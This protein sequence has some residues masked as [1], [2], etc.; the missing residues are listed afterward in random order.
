M[1][2][3]SGI[4]TVSSFSMQERAK[5]LYDA[6]T[7]ISNRF[8]VILSWVQGGT[9]SFVLGG[10]YTALSLAQWRGGHQIE[11]DP[12]KFQ[13][14]IGDLVAFNS[15]A[16]ALVIGLGNIMSALPEVAKATGA[17]EKIFEIF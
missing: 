12:S 1:E 3:V 7:W 8:G 5:E 10:F 9:F 17:A 15:L 2:H 13:E 6:A 16:V 11:D 14:G 4:R